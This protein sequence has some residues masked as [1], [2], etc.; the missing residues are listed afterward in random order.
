MPIDRVARA[1]RGVILADALPPATAPARRA[2]TA[3]GR[4]RRASGAAA[5][6][7][8]GPFLSPGT[9]TR[10]ERLRLLEGI[11]TVLDGVYTHL[12]LKRARYGIDP[13]QRLRI[14][15]S[16]VDELSDDAFHAALADV[17]TR[18]RDAHTRYAGP[19]ALSAKVAALPFLVEMIGN[20]DAPTYVVTKVGHGLASAFR[21][22]V[23]LEYWNGVPIDRAVQ[24]YSDD[25][26]G[27]RPD[28]QRAWATQSLTLRS[29][30]YGPPPDEHWVIV[31]FRSTTL[32]GVPTGPAREVKIPWQIVDSSAIDEML[33]GGPTGRAARRL[34][35]TRAIDP[36]AAAVRRAKMLLFAPGALM[37]EQATAPRKTTVTKRKP[38]AADVIATSLTDTLKALSIA[39]PGGPY[40]YLRIYGFDTEPDPFLG[41]LIR[42][43][44][45]LP[46]RGLILDLRG[47]PG[48]Y[49]WA[50]EL[51]LQLFTPKPITPT[52]F[53][54]LATPF[55]RDMTA[56]ASLDEELRPWKASLEAAVRNGELYS[57]PIP[58]TDPAACNTI[59]QRYGGPVVLVG[60]STTYSAGDLFSAGFVDNEIGPFV[61]VG[62]ATGAGGANV[63]DYAEMRS[64]LAGSPI[65]LPA[66]PD[67]IGLSLAF[68]RATRSGPSEGVPIEDI[69]VAG[70]PYAMTRDDLLAGNRDLIAH[71]IELLAE[72]PSS[73]LVAELDRPTRSVAVTTSGL[74]RLDALFDGHPGSSTVVS[75]NAAVSVT[76]PKGTKLVE[77]T[78]WSG[79]TVRQRRRVAAT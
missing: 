48:G 19:S 27:G 30:R 66:L 52:R 60:D 68:R 69:G 2:G 67:G 44:P 37:G 61:C 72:Q 51:A 23:V 18:L 29:L 42:L 70:A 63:W 74:T 26:V 22:G 54:V 33:A 25:E 36:A 55:T 78:G 3:K 39:A 73:R 79:S 11:E 35:R 50:A 7:L 6:G 24:R 75:E 64:A 41:E 71:C 62:E 40:G 46:D 53:S 31:G 28:S 1:Q 56:V 8:S 32:S 57:Q 49:I 58:L 5:D 14:L 34:R 38:P 16:Q 59:G 43:I 13:V 21:P 17:V 45:L 9:L 4:A 12:P 77:L 20:A 15:R 47:N 65:A 76:Y 10:T